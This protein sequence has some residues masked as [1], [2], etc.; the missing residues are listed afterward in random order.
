[1]C[2]TVTDPTTYLL[3]YR[4]RKFVSQREEN[5][6]ACQNLLDNTRYI[7]DK[8]WLENIGDIP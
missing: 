3:I 8:L 1:M 6:Y 5:G 7:L 2:F 4:L